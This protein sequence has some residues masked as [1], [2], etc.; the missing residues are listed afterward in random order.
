MR[1]SGSY[2]GVPDAHIGRLW[3]RGLYCRQA[4][5]DAAVAALAWLWFGFHYLWRSIPSC[6]CVFVCGWGMGYPPYFLI[7]FVFVTYKYCLP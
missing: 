2:G 7:V 4:P 6:M 5:D 3:T 1:S